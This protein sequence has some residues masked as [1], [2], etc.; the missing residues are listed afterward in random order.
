MPSFILGLT[1]RDPTGAVVEEPWQYLGQPSLGVALACARRDGLAGQFGRTFLGVTTEQPFD[2][3]SEPWESRPVAADQAPTLAA[4]DHRLLTLGVDLAEHA[5]PETVGPPLPSLERAPWWRTECAFGPGTLAGVTLRRA[6]AR[7]PEVAREAANLAG[8]CV[9][10]QTT[11]YSAA[12][13]AVGVIV[14]LLGRDGGP[15]VEPLVGWLDV[16]ASSTLDAQASESDEARRARVRRQLTRGGAPGFLIDGLVERA[17]RHGAA[18]R[19]CRAAF[20]AR[21]ADLEALR[22]RGLLGPSTLKLLR[23]IRG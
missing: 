16:V 1:W 8:E 4:L 5:E 18:A 6:T 15:T 13:P 7:D 2:G 17:V 10:H 3:A 9:A 22:S 19:A 20:S 11:L 21:Q 14:D 12:A 23:V